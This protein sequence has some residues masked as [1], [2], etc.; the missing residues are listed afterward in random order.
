MDKKAHR[1]TW[2][3]L[4][5]IFLAV[6][7]TF[8]IIG[9]TYAAPLLQNGGVRVGLFGTVTALADTTIILDDGQ[10]V[11]TDENTL[12]LVP[13]MGNASLANIDQGDRLAIVAVEIDDGSLLAL[14]VLVVPDEPVSNTHII[15]VVTDTEN[16]VITLTDNQGTAYTLELP[17]GEVA[18]VGDS[19]TVVSSEDE[20]TG[21]LVAKD[22]AT[23]NDVI[24]RLTGEIQHAT[25]KALE[26]LQRLLEDN[27]DER[28]TALVNAIINASEEAQATLQAV[29]EEA[30]LE[31]EETYQGVGVSE[32][33]SVKVKGFITAL[34]LDSGIGTVTIRSID[35]GEVTLDIT[36]ATEIQ[37]PIEVGDFVK[38]KYNLDELA[39]LIKLEQ[40]Q[41]TFE[42]T[43]DSFSDT[44][45]V[46]DGRTFVIETETDTE[47][48]LVVGAEATI[49]A[50]PVRGSF[51]A[52]YI[53]VEVEGEEYELEEYRLEG[54]ITT[55]ISDTEIEVDGLTVLITLDTEIDGTLSEDAEV[56]VRATSDN[57]SVVALYIKVKE[58]SESGEEEAAVWE[59]EFEGTISELISNV[60]IVVDDLTVLITPDT[61]IDGPLLEDS[62]V[63]VRGV[64]SDGKLIATEIKVEED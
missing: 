41:L 64:M 55:I 6:V 53:K 20:E 16:G 29:L 19:L 50:L 61:D 60:E 56:E 39:V 33:P 23:I 47:G 14:D 37:D 30:Q 44:E 57:D 46:L 35:D 1:M 13:G 31:L 52:R 22:V 51:V 18:K 58:R 43:I 45:L 2:R 5:L 26:R 59:I 38:A 12:F 28:L 49:D 54:T 21:E 17:E 15:G 24:D 48:A 25:G 42:G 4:G 32:G 7:M 9:G 62:E 27:G 11:A 63:V 34:D 36:A 40:D 10:I 3:R 8:A